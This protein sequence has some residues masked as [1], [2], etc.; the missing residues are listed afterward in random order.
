MGEEI[1]IQEE[2]EDKKNTV[3]KL[4]I[5][6]EDDDSCIIKI[7]NGLAVMNVKK[8]DGST[9]R[10]ILKT[11]G[12][13]ESKIYTSYNPQN[14]SISKRNERIIKLSE[15]LKQVEIADMLGISQ[16]LV[17]KILKESKK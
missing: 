6:I 11:D 2:K 7:T 16:A 15:T 4:P 9:Q 5:G 12:A 17:S 8:T 1:S 10:V 3:L 13:M 14:E